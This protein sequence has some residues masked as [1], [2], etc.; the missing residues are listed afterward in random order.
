MAPSASR[1]AEIVRGSAH[2][3]TRTGMA[4]QR[5]GQHFLKNPAW[6][7]RILE[8]LPLQ[9]NDTWV[10]IGAGHGEMTE[11]LAPKVGRLL[12]VET[13]RLL[14]PA[15]EQ[16]ARTDWRNVEIVAGDIL[17]IDLAALLRGQR[18]RIYGN[19]PYYITS[20][21]LQCLFDVADHIASIHIVIQLE[22]AERIV[23]R[24][25]SRDY[26]YLSTLCQ[27]FTQPEIE[28]R[29]PPGAFQPPPKVHSALVAMTLPGA[30]AALNVPDERR[31]LGFLQR[32]FAQ[33][34][35]TLRNNL[36]PFAS[37]ERIEQ[38]FR[39]CGLRAAVRA[40]Q[41]SLEQFAALFR[42]FPETT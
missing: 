2:C 13:D 35:K 21:I 25:G 23:A 32:C 12:A 19:L 18:V 3:Y 5:L 11:L 7:S 33:K 42:S 10:E 17:S 22:V 30:R 28:L 16:R 37:A 39:E 20:P 4:R 34:R 1:A 31:F 29:I 8:T 36:R 9:S 27:F 40:E 41:L 38:A 6:R 15:L 26:G 14:L 24:P